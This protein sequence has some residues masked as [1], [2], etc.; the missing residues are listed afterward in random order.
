ME[1][2][3]PPLKAAL[4]GCG[5][6]GAH[7]ASHLRSALPP[8]WFPYSHAEALMSVPEAR[9]EAVCDNQSSAAKGTAEKF[10][11]PL[12]YTD[13]Q[14]MLKEIR[15]DLLLI[16]TRTQ[17]RAEIIRDA[18]LMGV[19]GIHLEKPLARSLADCRLALD[20]AK[21]AGVH[22]SYGTV[23]R[24][25]DVF[26]HARE[27]LQRGHLGPLRNVTVETRKADLL[28]SHP[29]NFDLITFFIGLARVVSVQAAMEMPPG[30]FQG[31]TLDADPAVL[32]ALI[33][34]ENDVT[35]A[36]C[37]EGE[38]TIG[39]NASWLVESRLSERQRGGFLPPSTVDFPTTGSG[40]QHALARLASAVLGRNAAPNTAEEI[41]RSNALGLACA[42]S[43]VHDGQ[44]VRL[45]DVPED[46]SVTGRKGGLFA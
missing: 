8:V 46:F 34:F 43:A 18:A 23:R 29:H 40:T 7:T 9:L 4:I 36:C 16:A 25:M 15:P 6:I 35:A 14:M 44:A 45:E 41:F 17:G 38:L 22:L 5:R 1:M 30:A 32:G 28:W 21:A 42:W 10:G 19:R 12:W 11:V 37:N 39:G 2:T 13:H 27:R 20:A 31:R 33:V 26:V 3:T 24:C